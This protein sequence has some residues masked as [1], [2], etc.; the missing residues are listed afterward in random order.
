MWFCPT[1]V[2]QM[3][4]SGPVCNASGRSPESSGGVNV[5][6]LWVVVSM[7]K[8]RLLFPDANQGLP[9]G[10]TAPNCS[11]SLEPKEPPPGNS[12]IVP[13]VEIRPTVGV[14]VKHAN[15]IARSLAVTI[16]AGV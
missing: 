13:D 4:P 10:P 3:L 16:A 5:A 1:V 7:L 9:S 12:A 14:V 2:I 15:H 11:V 8:T 6:T